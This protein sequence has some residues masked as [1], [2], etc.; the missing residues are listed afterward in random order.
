MSCVETLKHLG[1]RLTSQRIAI[2]EALHTFDG[3][4]TAEDIY[5]E[6]HTKHP[7]TNRSTVYRTLKLLKELGMVA[8]TDLG[9]G[10]LCYHHVEKGHHHHLICQRCGKVMDV[11]ESVLN[12]FSEMLIRR[13]G[14]VADMKH[15]GIQGHCLECRRRTP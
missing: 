8:E 13:F 12:D 15:L 1:Y 7:N 14:F 2:L 9:E 11:D 4:V 5:R 3:H 10:R 6:A